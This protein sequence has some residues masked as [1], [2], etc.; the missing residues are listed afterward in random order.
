[1]DLFPD[2]QQHYADTAKDEQQA[3]ISGSSDRDADASRDRDVPSNADRTFR[4]QRERNPGSRKA[5]QVE[6]ALS[7]DSLVG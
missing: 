3:Q 2:Y 6:E 1:M 4:H 7:E 5:D